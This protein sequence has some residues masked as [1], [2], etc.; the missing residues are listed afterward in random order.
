MVAFKCWF[1]FEGKIFLCIE[2]FKI[3]V[4]LLM[5]KGDFIQAHLKAYINYRLIKVCFIVSDNDCFWKTMCIGLFIIIIKEVS[6]GWKNL[7][8]AWT[9]WEKCRLHIFLPLT[10]NHSIIFILLYC[11]TFCKYNKCTFLYTRFQIHSILF[12]LFNC[13]EEKEKTTWKSGKVIARKEEKWGLAG[14]GNQGESI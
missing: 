4:E 9:Y 8:N 12:Y 3:P 13:F 2:L 11:E 7:K 14:Q 5:W 1:A 6:I 10:I